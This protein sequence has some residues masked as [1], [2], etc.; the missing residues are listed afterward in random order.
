PAGQLDRIGLNFT[1]MNN[2]TWATSKSV[3][4]Y[5]IDPDT[6][7]SVM[8]SSVDNHYFLRYGLIMATSFLQGYSSAITNAGTTSV[9]SAGISSTHDALNPSSKLMVGLGQIG[10]TMSNQTQNYIN[11]PPTVR[12]NAGVGLGILFMS[13]LS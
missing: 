12:I 9:T 10:Q 1:L 6:A 13:D 5:A 8:A 11:V 3:N 2:D 4:A 7:R